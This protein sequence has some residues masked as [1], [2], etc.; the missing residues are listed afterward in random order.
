M[1]KLRQEQPVKLLSENGAI[2]VAE[3]TRR[4]NV[5]KQRHERA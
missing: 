3:L 5:Y 1:K 4:L 2:S